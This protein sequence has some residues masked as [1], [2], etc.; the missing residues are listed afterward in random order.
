MLR[1]FASWCVTGSALLLLLL[2]GY[3]M[4]LGWQTPS[5]APASSEA[6]QPSALQQLLARLPASGALPAPSLGSAGAPSKRRP[7]QDAILYVAPGPEREELR[8][9]GEV[10]GNTPYM[11]QIGCTRGETLSI[12]LVQ[13]DGSV[14]QLTRVCRDEIRIERR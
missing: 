4:L 3:M 9:G 13:P 10:L 11:G 2:G 6:R 12:E 5:G 14:K 1:R 7:S 8:V